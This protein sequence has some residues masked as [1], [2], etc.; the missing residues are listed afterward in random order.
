[1]HWGSGVITAAYP[2]IT[3]GNQTKLAT[4]NLT[5]LPIRPVTAHAHLQ[6]KCHKLFRSSRCHELRYWYEHFRR[7]AGNSGGVD[8]R[9]FKCQMYLAFRA[10]GGMTWESMQILRLCC[11]FP[12]R[13]TTPCP[14]TYRWITWHYI[15]K[16][17]CKQTVAIFIT[18][19]IYYSCKAL[20]GGICSIGEKIFIH[21]TVDGL[22]GRQGTSDMSLPPRKKKHNYIWH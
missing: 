6:I 2:C 15:N 12:G 22:T 4:P 20:R 8:E 9:V 10:A 13:P 7:G 11:T 5:F 14:R 16:S 19:S 1:M 17:S 21:L 18:I 3:Y